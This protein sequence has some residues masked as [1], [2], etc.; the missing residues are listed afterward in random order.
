MIL[1][2]QEMPP[3]VMMWTGVIWMNQSSQQQQQ[4]SLQEHQQYQQQWQAHR[5]HP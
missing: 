4:P 2:L 1:I 5:P 3:R